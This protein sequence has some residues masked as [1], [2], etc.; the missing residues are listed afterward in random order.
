M[1]RSLNTNPCVLNQ[2]KNKSLEPKLYI[3]IFAPTNS[4][5]Q[6]RLPL[7]GFFSL[8]L[9]SLT[10]L[11]AA[12]SAIW[13]QSLLGASI[14]A[15]SIATGMSLFYQAKRFNAIRTLANDAYLN[16]LMEK[17]LHQPF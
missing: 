8:A 17:A 10:A 6:F 9:S 15:V 13:T 7:H 5:K 12:G 1:A 11:L 16:P 3:K 2:V 4:Q 14:A